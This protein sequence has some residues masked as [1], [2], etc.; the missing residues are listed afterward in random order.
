M[1]KQIRYFLEW[2]LVSMFFTT[3]KLLP[4]DLMSKIMG[5][6]VTAIGYY[7]KPTKVARKN[8]RMVYPELS[9]DEIE[10]IIV[11]IWDNLGRNFAE[12]PFATSMS[13]KQ[14]KQRVNF[15]GFENIEPLI[16]E[17]KTFILFSAHFANW[18]I[19]YA[20]L[21]LYKIKTNMIY[22]WTNNPYVNKLIVSM[23]SAKNFKM[24]P[25]GLYGARKAV[26]GLGQG[27]VLASFMDQKLNEGLAIPF[28]GKDA[29]TP[30]L[31]ANLAAKNNYPL[32]PIH[33]VRKKGV[34]FD[35]IIDKPLEYQKFDDPKKTSH[36]I[37]V[38][39]NKMIEGWINKNP[40]Q[41]FWVHNRWKK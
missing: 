17:K 20:M 18:E 13:E 28:F 8:L 4:V 32:I 24:Q 41:W 10:D 26:K 16:K 15:I 14:F 21:S 40:G 12:Y 31:A 33:V 19:I 37:L 25:K 27:E 5:V 2:L 39:I 38:K 7:L 36:E 29:M 9:K 30:P 1:L 34:Y 35:L 22:R 11:K 23:R 6:F 3:F